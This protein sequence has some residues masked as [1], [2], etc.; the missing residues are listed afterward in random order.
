M[1]LGY[2]NATNE[3]GSVLTEDAFFVSVPVNF[4]QRKESVSNAE[5]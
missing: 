5:A 1:I 4:F 2:E 3:Y